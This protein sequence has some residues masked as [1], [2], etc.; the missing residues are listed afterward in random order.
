[1]QLELKYRHNF[2]HFSC[3]LCRWSHT[4][5]AKALWPIPFKTLNVDFLGQIRH[6]IFSMWFR[7]ILFIKLS[8]RYRNATLTSFSQG[9]LLFVW[10]QTKHF[11]SVKSIRR[12][13][14]FWQTAIAEINPDHYKHKLWP[15]LIVWVVKVLCCYVET[16]LSESDSLQQRLTGT[17]INSVSF[18]HDSSY[19]T[20]RN[21]E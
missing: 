8:I 13:F 14:L 7:W 19:I 10:M 12:Y 15:W 21:M 3:V 18:T 16:R 6:Q 9:R 1:M 4:E 2:L 20:S 17:R 11:F 5:M